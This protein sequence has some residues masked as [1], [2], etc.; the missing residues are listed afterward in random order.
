V[1]YITLLNRTGQWQAAL[2]CLHARRF[3]PWEGGEGLVSGQYV[4][5]HRALGRAALAAGEAEKALRHFDSARHYPTNLGEG[6]HLLTQE[7]DLDYFSGLAARQSGNSDLAR[8]YWS[9][10]A[11]PMPA[12]GIHSYFQALALEALGNARAAN[13]L[14]L[15][16]A[17]HAEEQM[18]AEPKID[19]F[20][21]SLP[22]LLLFDDDLQKRNRIESLFLSALA[23]HGLGD[24][25]RA[26]AQ[27]EMVM[28]LDPSHL[29]AADMLGWIKMDLKLAPITLQARAGS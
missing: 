18:Q 7:R 3:S 1:E 25:E 28:S 20:A 22:D 15:R 9:A 16:M 6:K 26:T 24:R 10:A 12:L 11:A 21:T 4:Y 27:L 5:A 19:Y 17:K 2:E 23:A 8:T 14:L 29:S 13:A